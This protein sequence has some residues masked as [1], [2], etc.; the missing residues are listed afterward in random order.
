MLAREEGIALPAC[1]LCIQRPRVDAIILV[2][3][4]SHRERSTLIRRLASILETHRDS[5]R[6]RRT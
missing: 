4:A 3:A 5:T 1:R 2:M 6:S